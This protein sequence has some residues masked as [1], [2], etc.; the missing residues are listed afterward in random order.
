MNGYDG[1]ISSLSAE[2]M[3]RAAAELMRMLD[4]LDGEHRHEPDSTEDETVRT[5]LN[6]EP[7]EYSRADSESTVP[8][9][10]DYSFRQETY[11]QNVSVR[12]GMEEISDFFSRDCRRYDRAFKIY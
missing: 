3:L 12:S 7:Y 2:D 5:E 11:P 8:V 6:A 1:L 4:G 9:T 10:A